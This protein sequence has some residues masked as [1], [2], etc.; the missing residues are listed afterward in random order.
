M[1]A[2][3]TPFRDFLAFWREAEGRP[4]SEQRRLWHRLYADRHGGMFEPYERE[5]GR[6]EERL[7]DALPRF[8]DVAAQAEA[9]F[10]SLDAERVA[11]R[12]AELFGHAAEGRA[13]A[14]VGTFG[15]L[16]WIDEIDGS[17]AVFFALEKMPDLGA[18]AIYVAHELS[19]LTHFALCSGDWAAMTPGLEVICEGIAM[20]ATRQLFP[21]A[22]PERR[23]AVDDYAAYEA[24]VDEAWSWAVPELL[25][26][27]DAVDPVQSHR[28]LWPDWARQVHDVPESF[29]YLVGERVIG[30][31]L[32]AHSLAEIASWGP[33]RARAEA[34][35]VL[36]RA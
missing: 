34:R 3:E 25:A 20:Q 36:E 7:G 14:L 10:A 1:I 27:F 19:H 24:A 17:F 30:E 11:A 6:A 18:N 26:H 8:A 15:P 2:V 4:E 33:E 35:A 9:R 16:A 31:L 12:V 23:F 21:E 29:G 22:T 32:G 28:F 5:F 13:I